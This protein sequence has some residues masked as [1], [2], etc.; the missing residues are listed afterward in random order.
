[1]QETLFD[2]PRNARPDVAAGERAAEA[3]GACAS[4]KPSYERALF[5]GVP[6]YATRLVR[7]HTFAFP[8]RTQ[9]CSPDAVAAVLRS[10]FESRDREEFVVCL[11]DT[12][13]WD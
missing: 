11:L 4:P 3:S 6:L 13:M 8:E 9:V 2:A 12:V 1:M 7:E 5:S 10:Y